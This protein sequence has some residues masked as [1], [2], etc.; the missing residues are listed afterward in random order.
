MDLLAF[1][2]IR[3]L[4]LKLNKTRVKL[5]KRLINWSSK[6]SRQQLVTRSCSISNRRTK[7]GHQWTNTCTKPSKDQLIV[8][9]NIKTKRSKLIHQKRWQVIVKSRCWEIWTTTLTDYSTVGALILKLNWSLKRNFTTS[10]FSLPRITTKFET[11]KRLKK[12]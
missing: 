2:G 12:L 11:I 9:R 1:C 8:I 6:S 3:W 5:K 7:S 10:P 4:S